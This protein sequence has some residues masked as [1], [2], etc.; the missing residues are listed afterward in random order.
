MVIS[1]GKK[2][3]KII[4]VCFS[5]GVVITGVIVLVF[6]ILL[7]SFSSSVGGFV[8]T[9][10]IREIPSPNGNYYL[11]LA[12]SDQGALGG[13]SL[14]YV[15]RVFPGLI[16]WKRTLY[17]GSWGEELNIKWVENHK[18]SINEKEV[19]IFSGSITDIR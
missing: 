5:S 11:V 10:E 18:V 16:Q 19:N 15:K 17:I 9:R 6:T 4:A 7:G 3:L 1:A 2:A 14:V 12:N 8:K 13:N